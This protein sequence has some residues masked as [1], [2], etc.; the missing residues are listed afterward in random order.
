[1]EDK[2]VVRISIAIAS[3]CVVVSLVLFSI[4]ADVLLMEVTNSEAVFLSELNE[5]GWQ[6][7]WWSLLLDLIFPILYVLLCLLAVRFAYLKVY[8]SER[9]RRAGPWMEI[10]AVVAGVADLLENTFLLIAIGG[11][12]NPPET[13]APAPLYLSSLFSYIK[14]VGLAV[15]IAYATPAL[16]IAIKQHRG[17]QT[18]E[19]KP[20]GT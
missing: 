10:V 4:V 18:V 14:W 19:S 16:L 5:L 7:V 2:R 17:G 15:V 6:P 20:R 12:P 13:V 9:A 1:M 3:F 11:G 8:S